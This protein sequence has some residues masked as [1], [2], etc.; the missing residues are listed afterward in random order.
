MTKKRVGDV[1]RARGRLGQA[2]LERALKMQQGKNLRL[3]EVLLRDFKLAKSEVAA[4]IEEV[5]G[6]PYAQCP[7]REISQE[8]LARIPRA[9]AM[10]CC[11]LRMITIWRVRPVSSLLRGLSCSSEPSQKKLSER[12]PTV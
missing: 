10:R 11:A 6:I 9:V 12:S 2:D 4:A 1:L 3:G 5:Q 7:P 8:T